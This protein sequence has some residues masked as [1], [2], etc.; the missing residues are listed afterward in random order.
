L[1][2]SM[3]GLSVGVPGRLKRRATRRA[4]PGVRRPHREL[5]PVV[6]RDRA[7]A[8]ARR[9]RTVEHAHHARRGQRRGDLDREAHPRDHVDDVE[10]PEPPARIQ[11]VLVKS[12]DQHSFVPLAGGIGTRGSRARRVRCLRRTATPSLR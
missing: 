10:R 12:I 8:A 3:N 11:G 6:H 9:R 2:L 4:R 5:R 1:K 7:R